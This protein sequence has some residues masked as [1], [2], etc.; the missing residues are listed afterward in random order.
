MYLSNKDLD[1]DNKMSII[2]GG[3]K[4]KEEVIKNKEVRTNNVGN[5]QNNER[6][7]RI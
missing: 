2:K 1:K 6:E 7:I 3:S 4:I 5:V